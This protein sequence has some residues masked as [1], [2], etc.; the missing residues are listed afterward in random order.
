MVRQ[1]GGK[2]IWGDVGE[3]N[4][5]ESSNV[6]GAHEIE[7]LKIPQPMPERTLLRKSTYEELVTEIARRNLDAQDEATFELLKKTYSILK[8]IG[9]GS[10]GVVHLVYHKDLCKYFACKVIEKSGPINDIQSMKTEIEIMKRVKHPRVVSLHQLFE[11][12]K[13]MWLILELV[14]SGGLRSKLSSMKRR[15]PETLSAKITKQMLEGLQYLHNQGIVHRDLK[16]DN[17][18]FEGNVQT[19]S[20]KIADFGLSALLTGDKSYPSD[21]LERKKFKGMK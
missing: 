12:P 5:G 8:Q 21:N 13:C 6:D 1:T 2:I 9:K 7:A 14:E 17:I 4:R 3:S 20:V 18:L 15:F 10:S 16:I 11:T 19:G